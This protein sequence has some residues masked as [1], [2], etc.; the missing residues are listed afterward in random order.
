[1]VPLV[2]FN[3]NAK[4]LVFEKPSSPKQSTKVIY[5]PEYTNTENISSYFTSTNP[6]MVEF[7]DMLA[8]RENALALTTYKIEDESIAKIVDT[9]N[10]VVNIQAL[11][12]G[13]TRLAVT[14]GIPDGSINIKAMVNSN[15]RTKYVDIVV[16]P[17][18]PV[19][20][21]QPTPAAT[22]TATPA[23]TKVPQITPPQT[24]DNTNLVAYIAL[25]GLAALGLVY[26]IKRKTK[27]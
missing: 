13:K 9:K 22:P 16:G 17:E 3:L 21:I 5:N 4:Q 6:L 10:G 23:P 7:G 15:A 2:D 8:V 18:A 1:M 27:K 19:N 11:S 20:T 14:V 24:G 12:E 25:L 26:A